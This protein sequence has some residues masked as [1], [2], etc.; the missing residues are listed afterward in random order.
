MSSEKVAEFP[1]PYEVSIPG[2][3]GWER[4]YPEALLLPPERRKDF[5]KLG[6]KNQRMHWPRVL[7]PFDACATLL[8][9]F[10]GLTPY[11][12]RVFVVPPSRGI[13]FRVINGY[14]YSHEV[15]PY[16]DPKLI[17]QRAKLFQQRMIYCRSNW[18]KIYP[19]WK[20]DMMRMFEE[21]Y[22]LY[23]QIK[24]L[25]ELEDMSIFSEVRGITSARRLVEVY[26]RVVHLYMTM[27][28]GYQYQFIGAA[29][30]TDLAFNGF[31]KKAFPGID[32]QT[33]GKMLTGAELEAFRP[34][35]EVKKLAHLAVDLG[36]AADVKRATDFEKMRFEFE[37]T[38]KG[39]KW[40]LEFDKS[41]FPWF[42]MMVTQGIFAQSD[43]E[44]WIENPNIILGF[45]KNY[46]EKIER[47]E[48]IERDVK[49]LIQEKERLFK[50]YHDMLKTDEEK[51]RFKQLYDLAS[52]FYVFVEDQVVYIKNI[53][54]ALFRRNIRKFAEILAKH[55]VIKEPDDI[56]YLKFGEI[57][58][59]LEELTCAWGMGEPPSQYWQREIEWRKKIIEKFEK[60]DRPLFMGPW[61]EEV[62]EPFS[63]VHGG[64]TTDVV[65]MYRKLPKFE[66]VKEI[67]GVAA[68]AGV[69]EGTAR[70]IKSSK[71]IGKVSPGEILVCP[72]TTP[73]WTPAFSIIKGI[74]TDQGGVM[75]HA[76]I[77]SR[78]YKIP[79][80]LCT[81]IGTS[82]IKNGDQIKIDGDKG[83]VT[84]LTHKN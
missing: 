30:A 75:S 17:E 3:E 7:K 70:V 57:K 2:T 66:E 40:C 38:E 8:P 78:E 4:M 27:Q 60:W 63:V 83:V 41:A 25:P 67:K 16:K 29:Y 80:V 71:D 10:L 46:I 65:N 54:Y 50:K 31:C 14:M 18:N 76:G 28:E 12:H 52:T 24:D 47:E 20:Q 45:L 81:C 26:E 32:D 35:E 58:S 53:N 56:Y 36:L 73:A 23:D 42:Y 19:K 82:V 61:K 5:E 68:S 44:C 59:A 34:D 84:I 72:H 13:N 74:V 55:G 79:A 51:A 11:Q 21:Q 6:W 69:V 1:N 77:V 22:S 33:I 39:R 9:A 62:T 64:I 48:K 49:A 37:K 43:E 15:P